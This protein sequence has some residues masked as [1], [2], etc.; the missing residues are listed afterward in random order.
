MGQGEIQLQLLGLGGDLTLGGG[1]L[2]QHVKE[3][4][5]KEKAQAKV[6]EAKEEMVTTQWEMVT[7]SLG[8]GL[9]LG[10]GLRWSY[11]GLGLAWITL[12]LHWD[13]LGRRC[14]LGKL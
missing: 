4:T 1:T 2:G 12:G 5:N 14:V 11:F 3:K 8:L 7:T 9:G 10:L 6:G 13:W